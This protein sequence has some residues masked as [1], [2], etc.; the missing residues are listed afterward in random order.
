MHEE[1]ISGHGQG[2]ILLIS[3]KFVP[4]NNQQISELTCIKCA[5]IQKRG[6]FYLN[7]FFGQKDVMSRV[8]RIKASS[9]IFVILGESHYGNRC[10]IVHVPDEGV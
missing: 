1:R 7:D 9:G 4:S 2:K 6:I 10:Y 8:Y 3:I 5:L